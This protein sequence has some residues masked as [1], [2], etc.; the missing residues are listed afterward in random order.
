MCQN[1]SN[2]VADAAAA[3]SGGRRSPDSFSGGATWSQVI[4]ASWPAGSWT[5]SRGEDNT[6]AVT[7]E[8]RE[9]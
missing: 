1:F 9:A 3:G 5:R 6:Q 2:G 4:S 7:K 8:E